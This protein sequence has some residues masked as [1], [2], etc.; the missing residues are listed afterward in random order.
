MPVKVQHYQTLTR[1]SRDKSWGN[2]LDLLG[3]KC[4][5]TS[6]CKRLYNLQGCVR[7]KDLKMENLKFNIHSLDR[8]MR[9]KESHILWMDLEF[10]NRFYLYKKSRD[11]QHIY[12]R[13]YSFFFFFSLFLFYFFPS[14]SLTL[15]RTEHRIRKRTIHAIF[16]YSFKFAL[17]LL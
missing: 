11:P 1:E 15:A 3:F 7:M 14:T 2:F 5:H 8:K 12:F 16:Q 4:L 6:L 17:H 13:L 9:I 10:Q